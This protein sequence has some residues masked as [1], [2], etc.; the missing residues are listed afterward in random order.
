M[1]SVLKLYIL[2]NPKILIVLC[3]QVEADY[4]I[5]WDGPY[6]FDE[7]GAQLERVEVPQVTLQRYL[8]EENMAS[9]PDPNVSFMEAITIYTMTLQQLI[10]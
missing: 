10:Q 9:F 5:D 3:V 7:V 1:A 8:T 6:G 4:G 2:N